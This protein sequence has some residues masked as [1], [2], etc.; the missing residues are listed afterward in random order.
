MLML[1]GSVDLLLWLDLM[2]EET[3][4]VVTWKVLSVLR[5]L[6]SLVICRYDLQVL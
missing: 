6:T 2:A 4:E 3:S 1:S 5:A